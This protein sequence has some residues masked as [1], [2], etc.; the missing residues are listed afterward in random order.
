LVVQTGDLLHGDANGVTSIPMELASEIA[1]AA[2]EFVAAENHV[3]DYVKASGAKDVGALGAKRAAMSEA[4]AA[5]R[6]RV[7]RKKA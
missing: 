7:S 4:M 1:D 6:R 2:E 3:L 5:L